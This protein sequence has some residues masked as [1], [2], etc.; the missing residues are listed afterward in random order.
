MQ[1]SRKIPNK[2]LCRYKMDG[3]SYCVS[4]QADWDNVVK[5]SERILNT[6]CILLEVEAKM[7]DTFHF[8]NFKPTGFPTYAYFKNGK[9]VRDVEDRTSNGLMKFLH[10]NNFLK[11]RRNRTKKMATRRR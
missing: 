8:G 2:V 7:L 1:K 6:D 9:H 11:K 3:C 5:Q 10:Q 4:S